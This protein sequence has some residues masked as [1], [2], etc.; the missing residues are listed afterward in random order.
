[1]LP[2]SQISGGIHAKEN[3]IMAIFKNLTVKELYSSIPSTETIAFL[4]KA[5]L[6]QGSTQL[7]V[8]SMEEL[9]LRGDQD[10]VH[11]TLKNAIDD[12]TLKLCTSMSAM[13]ARSLMESHD[14][15]PFTRIIGKGLL[16]ETPEDMEKTV[17]EAFAARFGRIPHSGQA[18]E[19]EKLLG[20]YFRRKTA[21]EILK[22]NTSF[23][24]SLTTP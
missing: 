2:R 8:S 7:A 10:I 23:R 1:M 24:E 17:D 20:L 5:G 21:E 22:M 15:D 11:E 3:S 18:I 14:T 13:V 6:E 12:G 9:L 4:M 19:A 16:Q